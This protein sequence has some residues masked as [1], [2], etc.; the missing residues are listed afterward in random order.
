MGQTNLVPNPSFED[1]LSCPTAQQQVYK[2]VG[3]TTCRAYPSYF[4]KCALSS[5]SVPNN[6]GGYQDAATG[7]AYMGLYSSFPISAS[8]REYIGRPLSSPLIVSTKYYVSMKVTL[9]MIDSALGH[10]RA[11]NK[12]GALFS[13]VAFSF[14]N[15]APTN[16]FAHFYTNTVISDTLNWTIIKGSFISDSAYQYINIGNFFDNNNTT[17]VTICNENNYAG[18]YYYIDDVCVSTDSMQCNTIARLGDNDVTNKIELYPN[19]TS[20]Q[21]FIR[22]N[23]FSPSG[24]LRLSNSV[25]QIIINNPNFEG[26]QVDLNN[27]PKGMYFIELTVDG[28]KYYQKIIHN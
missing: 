27:L 19:P 5:V 21:V 23:N 6:D 10:S 13:T 16:N 9:S 11:T 3:W 24:Y 25:G 28:K 7:K 22:I 18:A 4:N 14:S 15:P 26:R 8:N 2:A 1:T 12:L 20:D 17:I